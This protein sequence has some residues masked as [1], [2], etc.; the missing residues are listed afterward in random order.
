[1]LRA[2]AVLAVAVGLGACGDHRGAPTARSN[3]SSTTLPPVVTVKV[4]FLGVDGGPGATL[5]QTVEEAERLAVS[6][7]TSDHPRIQVQ[8][9][10]RPSGGTAAGAALAA[11]AL[12]ADGVVAVIGPQSST[13]VAGALPVLSAAGIPALTATAMT[14]D[15]A[16]SGWTSF[17]RVVADDQQQGVDDAAELVTS[18][19]VTSVAVLAG[20]GAGDQTRAAWVASDVADLGASVAFSTAV[21]T[22]AAA[23]AAARQ[24]VGTGVDGVFFSGTGAVARVLVSSLA[25]DGY[26]GTELVA[27]VPDGSATPAPAAAA[28]GTSPTSAGQTGGRPGGADAAEEPVSELDPIGATADGVYLSSPADD[29]AAAAG[30]GSALVFDD[31]F[32]AAFGAPPPLWGA[33]AYDAANMVL[34][35]VAA[36]ERTGPSIGAYLF[37]HT[38][39]GVSAVIG[40]DGN[41]NEVNP[42]VFVSQVRNGVPVQIAT[43][44]PTSS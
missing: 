16:E 37:N 32:R 12:V 27:A 14:T 17:F 1:V 40:F 20:A 5:S 42:P 29:P 26:Q 25:G 10:S 8:I 4:G 23:V 31:A 6:Q 3:A 19:H 34:A 38:W 2:G 22:P 28:T 44:T 7:F 33:E 13:E 30:G 39:N 18:L 9:D 41:G 35:A 11:R 21:T 36:G 24:I 43:V 15:L